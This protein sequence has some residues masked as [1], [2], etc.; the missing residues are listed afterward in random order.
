MPECILYKPTDLEAAA[1][2]LFVC[3]QNFYKSEINKEEMYIRYIHKLCDMHLQ[4][5][6]YTGTAHRY[7]QYTTT[8]I[9]IH[10]V[11]EV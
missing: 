8:Y 11:T 4:A 2:S 6:N 9:H 7:I 5:E 1:V 10:C 3:F